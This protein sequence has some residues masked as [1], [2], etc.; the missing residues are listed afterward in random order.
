MIKHLE[1]LSV[2]S[3]N[4][5]SQDITLQYA[6]SFSLFAN[7]P[8]YILHPSDLLHD[9]IWPD[10]ISNE[11]IHFKKSGVKEATA[12]QQD[13]MINEKSVFITS[14]FKD[15]LKKFTDDQKDFLLRLQNPILILKN[16]SDFNA[17][18]N[19]LLCS[20]FDEVEQDYNMYLL[21]DLALACNSSLKIL[22]IKTLHGES[23]S[24]EHIDEAE[25]EL[26]YFIPH[27]QCK[28]RTIYSSNIYKGVRSYIA[29]KG[30][31][32]LVVV[33][34]HKHTTLH[35]L[36]FKNHTFQLSEHINIPIL[37]L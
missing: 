5:T 27:L 14:I 18:K 35:N 34:R 1:S 17:V 29:Q 21:R 15:H 23:S 22:H 20:D 25:R 26:H 13:D 19:I 31:Y 10:L 8:L 7:I 2:F 30:I 12:I 33:I 9:S 11:F 6:I 16:E 4:K 37:L 24:L 3:N 28:I 32:D 36:F